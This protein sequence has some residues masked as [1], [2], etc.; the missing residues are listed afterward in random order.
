[1]VQI[2]LCKNYLQK[3]KLVKKLNLEYPDARVTIKSCIGMCKDCKSRPVA[4]VNGKKIK[5]KSIKKFLIK[6][7][8]EGI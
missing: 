8:D 3:K 5:K 6:L 7:K 1:M 4:L 2:K